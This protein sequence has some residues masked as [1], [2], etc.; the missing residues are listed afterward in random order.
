MSE[1][2]FEVYDNANEALHLSALRTL[3]SEGLSEPYSIY[4]YRYFLHQW[5]DLC[6]LA[7]DGQDLVGVVISKLERHREVGAYRGYI[8]M[9]VVK[10]SYRGKGLGMENVSHL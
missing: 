3:I 9:L 10:E 7:M 5:G 2:T 8:A 4:V 1:V 6:Y